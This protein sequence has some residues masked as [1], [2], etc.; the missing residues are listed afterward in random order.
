MKV[1]LLLLLFFCLFHKQ[2]L[3]NILAFYSVV[4]L[5]QTEPFHCSYYNEK[6][7]IDARAYIQKQNIH[8][9]MKMRK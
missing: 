6:Y 2:Y 3:K 8:E 7:E 5:Q 4:N 9:K 1:F